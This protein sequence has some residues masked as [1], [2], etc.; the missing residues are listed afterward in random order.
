VG[1]TRFSLVFRGPPEPLLAQAIYPL[2]HA[3]L[4][5]LEIFLVP[6]ARDDG[7]ATYQAVFS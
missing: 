5:L 3:G 2:R 6:I 1:V 4:G 7:G